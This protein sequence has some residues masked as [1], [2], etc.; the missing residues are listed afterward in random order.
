MERIRYQSRKCY[1]EGRGNGLQHSKGDILL[2][3]FDTGDVL[4]AEAT[5]FRELLLGLSRGLS[6][7]PNMAADDVGGFH[8]K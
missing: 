3:I 4:I 1:P 2:A 8:S 5:S 7:Y 6:A